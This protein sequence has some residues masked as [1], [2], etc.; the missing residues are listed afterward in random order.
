MRARI[1]QAAATLRDDLDE[2][3]PAHAELIREARS[4]W[5]DG[6]NVVAVDLLSFRGDSEA[7]VLRILAWDRLLNGDA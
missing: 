6:A 1:D 7:L 5:H 2:R 4:P 3:T